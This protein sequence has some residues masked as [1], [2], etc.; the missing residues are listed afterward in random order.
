MKAQSTPFLTDT[1][2]M[3]ITPFSQIVDTDPPGGSFVYRFKRRNSYQIR[4]ALSIEKRLKM[5]K[6]MTGNLL[7]VPLSP[8]PARPFPRDGG[9]GEDPQGKVRRSRS[10]H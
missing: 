10:G 9:L 4:W 8:P 2:S 3:G 7:R 5:T 6:K 1:Q